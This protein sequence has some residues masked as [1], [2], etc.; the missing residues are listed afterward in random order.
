MEYIWNREAFFI[1]Y[2]NNFIPL[3]EHRSLCCLSAEVRTLI[4]ELLN[5]MPGI[6]NAP[7]RINSA[8][9]RKLSYHQ[10]IFAT[11]SVRLLQGSRPR[12]TGSAD[13]PCVALTDGSDATR[14]RPAVTTQL[15]SRRCPATECVAHCKNGLTNELTIAGINAD[16]WRHVHPNYVT[17][18]LSLARNHMPWSAM[19]NIMKAYKC[20]LGLGLTL[21]YVRW[22]CLERR[23]RLPYLTSL[24]LQIISQRVWLHK[25]S[26]G[27]LELVTKAYVGLHLCRFCRFTRMN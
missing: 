11:R 19:N 5:A 1:F 26:T 3:S 25:P 6:Q 23:F 4:D 10:P 16:V 24:Q 8:V 20:K 9:A 7:S 12:A 15:G 21:I 14:S 13:R 18:W 17:F 2:L 27:G 22:F